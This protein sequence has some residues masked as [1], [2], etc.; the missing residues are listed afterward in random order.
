MPAIREII[1]VSTGLQSV[2]AFKN[3]KTLRLL[4][5]SQNQIQAIFDLGPVS[6][7]KIDDVVLQNGMT[8]NVLMNR[9]K[10]GQIKVLNPPDIKSVSCFQKFGDLA[11]GREAPTS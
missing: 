6:I 3:L 10:L 2:S 7:L 8:M 1:A 5:V 11:F 9:R 4:D